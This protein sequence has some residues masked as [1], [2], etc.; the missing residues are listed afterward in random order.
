LK[1]S[2]IYF[3]PKRNI[4]FHLYWLITTNL[5]VFPCSKR[6]LS[7]GNGAETP[8][9]RLHTP[10]D[11]GA[12]EG[13]PLQP[14]PDAS[15]AHRDRPYAGPVGAADQDLV[16]EQAHEVE[17]GQQAAQHQERAQE[18]GGRQRQPNTG[19]QEAL[20]AGRLQEAAAAVAAAADAAA[21][22]ATA[23]IAADSGDE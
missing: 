20:Q 1:L 12:G 16:P 13:I 22:A 6:I 7:A 11:P 5:L 19:S 15:A 14:L 2:L 18:D 9:H 4:Q 10:P 8:T 3:F 17:E 21:A 23:A